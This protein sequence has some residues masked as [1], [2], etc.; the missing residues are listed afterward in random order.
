M[1]IV[2]QHRERLAGVHGRRQGNGE[3]IDHGRRDLDRADVRVRALRPSDAPL[4]EGRTPTPMSG[5]IKEAYDDVV[6]AEKVESEA[7]AKLFTVDV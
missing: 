2:D 6:A 1:R 3:V 4:V 5:N 7:R